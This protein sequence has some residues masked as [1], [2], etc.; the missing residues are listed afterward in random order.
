MLVGMLYV[1]GIV[2]GAIVVGRELTGMEVGKGVV[3]V[4]MGTPRAWVMEPAGVD[5][6]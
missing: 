4:C 5:P 1:N 3:I 2:A 6:G